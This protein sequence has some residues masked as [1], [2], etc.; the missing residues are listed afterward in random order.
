[1]QDKGRGELRMSVGSIGINGRTS[2]VIIG[3]I[4][5]PILH[6]AMHSGTSLECNMYVFENKTGSGKVFKVPVILFITD[7]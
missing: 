6:T 3:I 5:H 4:L 2:G 7:V 1:M